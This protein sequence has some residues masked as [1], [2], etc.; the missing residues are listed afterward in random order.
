VAESIRRLE[1]RGAPAIGV[2]AAYALVLAVQDH[3]SPDAG[4]PERRFREAVSHLAT[5]R[6]TAVNLFTA[7]KRMQTCF[8]AIRTT[9]PLRI[10]E[11]LL[12]EARAIER[13]DREACAAIARYGAPLLKGVSAVLTH[14]HTGSLATA[15]G[16]TALNIIIEAATRGRLKRVY[17]DETRP[18]LQGARLTTWELMQHGI[19]AVLITDSSAGFVMQQRNTEAVLVGADRIAANGD[20]ANKIGTYGLAVLA[21]KHGIPFYVAAP[22]STID[23]ELA[24]GGEIPIELRAPEEITHL[25]GVQIAPSGVSVYAPAFDV[26]PHGLITAIVTD[27]GVLY[28]PFDE[29]IRTVSKA[30]AANV[31]RTV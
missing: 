27:K 13:D 29:A 14:C 9:D 5:T 17:V 8:E 24:S 22:V 11:S 6:P 26:T 1:I 30:G 28:P 25:R 12:G 20:T 3:A 7:L 2:A 23:P 31:E 16:G 4:T 19:D 18:L 10:H 15:G 21:E